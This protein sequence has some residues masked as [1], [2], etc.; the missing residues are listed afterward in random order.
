MTAETCLEYLAI[1][2]TTTF[3]CHSCCWLPCF[4]PRGSFWSTC[5][6]VFFFSMLSETTLPFPLAP[7]HQQ[8]YFLRE[9]PRTSVQ[10]F[11]NLVMHRS[12]HTKCSRIAALA[13]TSALLH[14]IV[15]KVLR[16]IPNAVAT[17][18]FFSLAS[19]HRKMSTFITK[20]KYSNTSLTQTNENWEIFEISGFPR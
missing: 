20:S 12:K 17:D 1:L 8:K 18:D 6:V 2:Q 13:F 7:G 4:R 5:E 15:L 16:E 14:S 3:Q 9:S 11:L 10:G 19:T